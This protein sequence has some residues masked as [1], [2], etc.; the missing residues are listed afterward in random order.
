MH[1]TLLPSL[2]LGFGFSQSN[3][4]LLVGSLGHAASECSF[5][6]IF[7]SK[8]A[9][10]SCRGMHFSIG[11]GKQAYG[12]IKLLYNTTGPHFATLE[13]IHLF[14]EHSISP[15][16]A[17]PEVVKSFVVIS[18]ICKHDFFFKKHTPSPIHITCH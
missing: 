7:S 5:Q 11:S 3:I 6:I 1:G 14:V 13:L 17:A 2:D 16:E 10:K 4:Y 9:V 12:A 18:K 15:A 8:D